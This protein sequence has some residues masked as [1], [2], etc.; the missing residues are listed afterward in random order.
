MALHCS[1]KLPLLLRG[2]SSKHDGD[3]YCLNCFDGIWTKNKLG[4]HK[5]VCRNKYFNNAVIPSEG[6]K[7][8]EFNQYHKSDKA[9]MQIFNL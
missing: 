5:K 1:K 7:I 8:L 3:F 6:T 2:I 9:P 4:S